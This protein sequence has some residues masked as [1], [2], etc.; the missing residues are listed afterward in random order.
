MLDRIA[1]MFSHQNRRPERSDPTL[2]RRSLLARAT[3]ASAGAMVAGS[4]ASTVILRTSAQT[5]DPCQICYGNTGCDEY[6]RWTYCDD[7]GTFYRCC[8][9]GESGGP[10]PGPCDTICVAQQV[11]CA[12]NTDG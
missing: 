10:F 7:D 9:C 8:T 6:V 5:P 12:R 11:G 3:Q 1:R 2:S 4:A